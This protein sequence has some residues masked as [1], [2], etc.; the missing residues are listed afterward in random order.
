MGLHK[1]KNAA[2]AG[3]TSS[4]RWSR[5]KIVAVVAGGVILATGGTAWA[6]YALF[7]YGTLDASA[8]TTQGLTVDNSTAKLTGTLVPGQTV[9][10]QA[11]VHNP[12]DYPV[13]VV[14]VLVKDSTVATVG[15][16]D[17]NST[18]HIIGTPGSTW[19]G[20]GGGT[21]TKQAIASTVTIPANQTKVVTV[22]QAV[23]QDASA[24]SLCGIHADFA[25]QANPASS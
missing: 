21:A 1:S 15:G 3:S 2:A 6:A 19:P 7:G 20:S 5:K 17:C 12:N 23:K 18:V 25:V 10:A 22:P 8:A 24:N 11:D 9:G 14:A 16:G 13:T 4:K